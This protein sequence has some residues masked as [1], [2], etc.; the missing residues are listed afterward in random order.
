MDTKRLKVC[1]IGAGACGLLSIKNCL[2]E[3]L[4]PVCYEKTEDIGGLWNYRNDNNNNG[5]VKI[6]VNFFYF[7]LPC[8][9][10]YMYILGSSNCHGIHS[11]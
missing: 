11:G 3:N 5:E 1:I 8:T 9:T 4:Q 6:F 10:I 7:S 2:E